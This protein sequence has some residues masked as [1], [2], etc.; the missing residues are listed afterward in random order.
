MVKLKTS[1]L[2]KEISFES[3][4]QAPEND[5]SKMGRNV[6]PRSFI[7]LEKMQKFDRI[8]RNEVEL[9]QKKRNM[10]PITKEPKQP[11]V[12]KKTEWKLPS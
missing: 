6:Y 7:Q 10:K 5:G 4:C 9:S 3:E 12:R 8:W 1:S 11:I 2:Q